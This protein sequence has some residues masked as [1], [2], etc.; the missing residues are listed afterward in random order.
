MREC[1]IE[2]GYMALFHF[3]IIGDNGRMEDL[4]GKHLHDLDEVREEAVAGARE[5]MSDRILGGTRSSH[6]RFEIENEVGQ[7][8]LKMPFSEAVD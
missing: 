8:V 7:S 3:H 1:S 2:G 4:E 5:I 6:W